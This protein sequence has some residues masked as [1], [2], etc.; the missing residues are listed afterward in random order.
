VIADHHNILDT[1][2][3]DIFSVT[4]IAVCAIVAFYVKRLIDKETEQW[5]LNPF[6]V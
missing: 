4:V 5:S 6:L 2:E 1:T 3:L